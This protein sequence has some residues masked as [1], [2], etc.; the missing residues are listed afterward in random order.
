MDKMRIISAYYH[1]I[2]LYGSRV[3]MSKA[4]KEWLNR[5]V[6]GTSNPDLTAK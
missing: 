5:A 2:S 6:C 1:E 3:G 4:Q